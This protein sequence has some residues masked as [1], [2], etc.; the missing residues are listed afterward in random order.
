M[1]SAQHRP[2]AVPFDD[3]LIAGEPA[4]IFN[5]S[6]DTGIIERADHDVHWLGHQGVSEGAQLPI[7]EVGGCE[8]DA[9]ARLLRFDKM[10]QA[11]V[12]NEL[13]YVLAIDL[14]EARKDPDQSSYGAEDF[15]GD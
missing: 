1:Q 9:S 15:I 5:K 2:R 12:A 6:I 4:S 8:E 3:E 7:A 14:G 13:I 10:L 11:V